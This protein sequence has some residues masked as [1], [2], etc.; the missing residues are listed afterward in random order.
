MIDLVVAVDDAVA[1]HEE[2]MARNPTHYSSPSHWITARGVAAMQ[3]RLGGFSWYNTLVPIPHSARGFAP[4][5]LMKYG[6]ITVAALADDLRNWR[7]LYI[8]GRMHKPVRMIRL[9]DDL[10]AAAQVNLHHA[11]SAALLLQA[12]R[13]TLGDLMTS[14]AG[15]SYA[16]DFRM[17]FGEHPDKV[18][19]IVRGQFAAMV[20]LYWPLLLDSPHVH[21][22]SL[23]RQHDLR[24][25][26]QPIQRD[27]HSSS[28]PPV[29]ES[30]LLV[31]DT[32]P[33]CDAALVRS[34]PGWVSAAM[35]RMALQGLEAPVTDTPGLRPA[36]SREWSL[37]RQR[38]WFLSRAARAVLRHASSRVAS[39]ATERFRR[40]GTALGAS[41]TAALASSQPIASPQRLQRQ[42]RLLQAGEE[43]V[44]V[45]SGGDVLE[46]ILRAPG[47]AIHMP[48][49]LTPLRPAATWLRAH[50]LS[51]AGSMSPD[52][53][54]TGKRLLANQSVWQQPQIVNQPERGRAAR[55]LR[56]VLA[57]VVGSAALSQSLK[58]LFSAGWT[59]SVVYSSAKLSKWAGAMRG[60]LGGLAGS[61][62]SAMIS[63]LVIQGARE[64]RPVECAC[65]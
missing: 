37:A 14:I 26:D 39:T 6:V 8:P 9:P 63:I 19:N 27:H 20:K 23:L 21:L 40:N 10:R 4:D 13:F 48:S 64:T 62:P 41:A 15:L 44:A 60:R 33:E 65:W 12:E 16:G 11:L 2:N 54:H 51:T 22:P 47:T 49:P 36:S 50:S 1:F 61:A 52:L 34:L 31:R 45:T 18:R 28:S 35:V 24:T 53:A 46:A 29:H 42:L 7:S 25:P 58:G 59:K 17:V 30:T 56:P 57:Q 3:E 43:A 5:Q 55:L 38:W 32:S